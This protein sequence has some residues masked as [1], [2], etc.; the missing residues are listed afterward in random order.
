MS[1]ALFM[2][3]FVLLPVHPI[4][5][6]IGFSEKGIIVSRIEV[7]IEKHDMTYLNLL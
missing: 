4:A 7:D 1:D 5:E 2:N 3:V 6:K